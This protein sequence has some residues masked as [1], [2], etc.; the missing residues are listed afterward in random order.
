MDAS[1]DAEQRHSVNALPA[2]LAA[3]PYAHIRS[4]W[5]SLN[6]VRQAYVTNADLLTDLIAAPE[7]D[8]SMVI[9]FMSEAHQGGYQ[10]WY[11]DE[12]FR[13]LHNYLAILATL[14][15]HARNLMRRYDG[16]DFAFQYKSRV[17]ILRERPEASFLRDLRNYLLHGSM[18]PL[19]IDITIQ[20]TDPVH[21]FKVILISRTLLEWNGWK[22]A[23]K[24][25]LEAH[26][27]IVLRPCVEAYTEQ[28]IALY[29]WAFSE[30][31]MVHAEDRD[32]YRR[33]RNELQGLMET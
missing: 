13:C 8:S 27:E 6:R 11:F 26:D 5:H 31:E 21:S 4:E 24:R 12:V 14:I 7:S 1:S 30:C 2:Q 33:L 10:Q 3:H 28:N 25:Y 20:R 23:S 9:R 15:D 16:T 22:P 17:D 32:D 29:E 19:S 18:V